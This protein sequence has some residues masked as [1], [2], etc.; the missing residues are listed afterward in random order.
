MIQQPLFTPD[1]APIPPEYLVTDSVNSALT[2]LS[3]GLATTPLS[4][5][6][7]SEILAV[8]IPLIQQ[9]EGFSSKPYLDTSK[10]PTIGY[11]TTYYENDSRVT[12]VDLPISQARATEIL[13][14]KVQKE[15]LPGVRGLCPNLTTANQFAAVL[16]FAYNLGLGALEKSTLRINI[17]AN[18]MA[19]A[20]QQFLK[21]DMGDGKVV[22]GLEN[23]RL[24]EQA[25]F[26]A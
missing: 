9:F 12:M 15:F 26:L 7:D 18:D 24:K 17:L 16:S 21:W 10:I 13:T 1:Q 20:A 25:I 4:L 5:V 3:S 6:T 2:D 22:P 19:S 23:R 8:G 11:G 14:Y